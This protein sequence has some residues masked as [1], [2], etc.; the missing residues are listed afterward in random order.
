MSFNKFIINKESLKFN[1]L[2]IK[3][4]IGPNS[5]LCSVVKAEAYGHGGVVVASAL[6]D[7]SDFFAVA[8]F[9]E[10][11]ELRDRGISN[12][13]IVLGI[14]PVEHIKYCIFNDISVNISSNEQ[15]LSYLKRIKELNIETSKLK[16]HLKINT[17][18]NRLGFNNL[19]EFKKCLKL[20]RNYQEFYLEGIFTHFATKAN[21]VNFIFEQYNMFQKYTDLVKDKCII[22]HNNNSY[23]TLNLS[24]FNNSMVRCGYALYGWEQ[25]FKPVL[26]ITTQI[27]QINNIKNGTVGYDRTYV[28]HNQK[29]AV[30]PIGYADGLDRRL[31]NNFS[32]LVNGKY[33][34]IVGNICM[35]MC[36][37]DVTN[38]QNVDV[39]TTVTVLGQ[40]KDKCLSITNYAESL[41][42]SPYE[43]LLKFKSTRMDIVEE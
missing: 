11:M 8:C 13:I 26:K 40:D 18:L 32:L 16:I 9:N 33:A 7:I 3:K 28:A 41:N 2:K 38:I 42:T 36:M 34:K 27:V 25:G 30:V 15:L 4:L 19:S 14:V 22:I 20:I 24:K 29:I 6:K 10:A 21:D 43:I 31:S 1:A 35:D 12:P 37:I 23:A 17:G 5:K 39:G